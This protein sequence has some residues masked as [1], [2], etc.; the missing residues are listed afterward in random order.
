VEI[1]LD[2][3]KAAPVA[4]A[5]LEITGTATVAGKAVTRKAT[6]A[7]AGVP[8]ADNLRLAV[9]LVPPFKVVGD[10]DLRLVPRGTVHRRRYKIE[11]HGFAGPLE[12]RLA[13]HQ[14]R[15]LQGVT[16]PTLTVPA[17]VNEFEYPVTLPP[18]METGR[19]SR[20]C[21]MAVGVIKD[22][23]SE[24]EVGYSSE[25]Q[26]EQIIAV[27]ETGRLGLECARTSVPA[28]P[29]RRVELPVKVSRGQGLTGPVKVELALPEHVRDLSAE[30][31]VVPAEQTRGV[32]VLHF[33]R[34]PGP[35]TMPVVVRASLAAA[36]GPVTAEAR[37]EVAPEQ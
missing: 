30:P 4:A 3:D 27:V 8:E 33:G 15:H 12:V 35:F 16:G 22:G 7:G 36:S 1:T 11:R 9:A 29:G 14:A 18:W 37:V 34:A 5:R 10:Y 20:S 28:A 23:T 24:Y 32:L 25:A 19:T 31:L 13:D 6:L 26:N 21:V 17:G 2:A